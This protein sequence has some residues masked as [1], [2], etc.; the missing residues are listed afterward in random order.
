MRHTHRIFSVT[1]FVM[2]ILF[3]LSAAAQR[4][5][6]DSAQRLVSVTG[7][8]RL[9]Y[10]ATDAPAQEVTISIPLE[11]RTYVTKTWVRANGA[12]RFLLP[13]GSHM[14]TFRADKW[15]SRRIQIAS[16]GR[17]A[18]CQVVLLAGDADGDDEVDWND[19]DILANAFQTH[20]GDSSWDAR[21]DFD[22]DGDVDDD[23][24]NILFANLYCFG[25]R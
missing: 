13:P 2:G 16:D 24:A 7:S 20:P 19:M 3:P 5:I 22:C 4:A 17:M 10:L 14:V 11:D 23:D 21:A 18:R 25:D 12:V 1:L 8:I 6:P 15:L 9:Q